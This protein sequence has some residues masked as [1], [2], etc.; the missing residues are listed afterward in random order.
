[1]CWGVVAGGTRGAPGV[2]RAVRGVRTAQPRSGRLWAA[3]SQSRMLS[4]VEY[5]NSRRPAPLLASE[6]IG[7]PTSGCRKGLRCPLA[8][9]VARARV[10]APRRATSIPVDALTH[11]AAENTQSV[12]TERGEA[13]TQAR[14]APLETGVAHQTVG[15]RAAA[16][17]AAQRSHRGGARCSGRVGAGRPRPQRLWRRSGRCSVACGGRRPPTAAVAGAA[18]RPQLRQQQ[19]AAGGGV[20]CARQRWHS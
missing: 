18:Q 5:T 8:S 9:R 2:R 17:L 1:V 20:A 4:C 6:A 19:R 7:L 3:L 15:R 10:T 12:H 11:G 13:H 16:A 14:R